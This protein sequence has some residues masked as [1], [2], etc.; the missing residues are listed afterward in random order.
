[1]NL[2]KKKIKQSSSTGQTTEIL[3]SKKQEISIPMLHRSCETI[4][5]YALIK[6][7]CTNDLKHLII[8]G[9]P[10]TEELQQAWNE[11]LFEWSGLIKNEKSEMIFQMEKEIARLKYHVVYV[12]N[13]TIFLW[14]RHDPSLTEELRYLG[15]D[16]TDEPEHSDLD[17]VRSLC[18]TNVFNLGELERE[19]ETLTKTLSG[20]K[21][22]EEEFLILVSVISKYQGYAIKTKETTALEFAATFNAYLAEAKLLRHDRNN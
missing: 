21:Q 7:Y 1:M 5:L 22:T 18:I 15:Y 19:L 11:I 10:T 14:Y 6:C 4:S 3:R 8:S 2:R 9:T 17:R 16:I 13:A 12:E 20:K